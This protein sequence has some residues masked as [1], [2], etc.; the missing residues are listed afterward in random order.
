MK[1]IISILL[2]VS[3]LLSLAAVNV[4]AASA[5]K[6]ATFTF[7]ASVFNASA[8]GQAQ[9]RKDYLNTSNKTV[10]KSTDGKT[11]NVYPGQVVWV[12]LHL[13]TGSKYYAGD[14]QTYVFYSTN[15]FK[16]TDQG[17]NCYIWDTN[18]KYSGVCSHVG[19]P[20]SKMKEQAIKETYPASWS[21]SQ[22]KAYGFYSVV[23]YPNPNVTTTVKASVDDDLV[24]FPIYVRSDAKVGEKGTIYLPSETIKSDSNKSGK[25]ML[26]NYSGGNTLGT[27]TSYSKDYGIDVSKAKLNFVVA[28]R[29][30]TKGDVNSD[31]RINSN[32]ALLVLQA[33]TGL[34]TLSDNQKKFAEVTNDGKVNSS[35]ALKILQ[36]ATGK[37]TKF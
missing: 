7:K 28:S 16:S 22:R 19:A 18:G 5:D 25:F 11:I 30:N 27:N 24:T 34:L 33:S 32:D 17:S 10:Y 21:E 35:D 13:K 23:M 3:M 8:S 14:L 37:L 2:I 6:T 1:K 31:G 29:S 26:S 12:T 4:Y 36:F 20:F 9:D 15:V